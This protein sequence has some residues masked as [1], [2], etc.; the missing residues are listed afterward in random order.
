MAGGPSFTGSASKGVRSQLARDSVPWEVFLAGL[1][2]RGA[3][4][5]PGPHRSRAAGAGAGLLCGP[6]QHCAGQ[7]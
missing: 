5:C 2:H 6:Q 1:P 7:G 4:T 3:L